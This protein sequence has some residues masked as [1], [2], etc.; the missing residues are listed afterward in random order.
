LCR[1]IVIFRILLLLFVLSEGK[2][3]VVLVVMKT[4][5]SR[6]HTPSFVS[7]HMATVSKLINVSIQTI[8][9]VSLTRVNDAVT[10][11]TCVAK[12]Y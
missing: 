2:K 5:K 7:G 4:A 8:E 12:L 10:Q 6:L 3:F 9:A 11:N 1:F